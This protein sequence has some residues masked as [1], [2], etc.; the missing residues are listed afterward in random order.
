MFIHTLTMV[1]QQNVLT[2]IETC[3]MQ[4][5][6]KSGSSRRDVS[7]RPVGGSTADEGS[8]TQADKKR[9]SSDDKGFVTWGI[10]SKARG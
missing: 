9:G 10:K 1:K 8:T 2:L 3:F 6:N 5:R 4:Q 7:N